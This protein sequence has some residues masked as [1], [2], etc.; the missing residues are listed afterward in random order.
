MR[1]AGI[2]SL[3]DEFIV[4]GLR[5]IRTFE[6]MDRAAL[7]EGRR[8]V[9]VTGL[10]EVEL[11][12]LFRYSS[13]T[14]LCE[15]KTLLAVPYDGDALKPFQ[16]CTDQV[17]A[18]DG[19]T[20]Y[21]VDLHRGLLSCDVAADNPELSFI[22]LPEIE[23]W[24]DILNHS[25]IL[26]ELNRTVGVCKGLVKF[27]DVDNGRFET[28]RRTN[29]FTVTT[30]VLNKIAVPAKWAKVSVL[31]VNDEL[32]TLPNFRDSP[33]PQSAPLCPMVSSKDVRLFHFILEEVQYLN[34]YRPPAA[35][36]PVW[37]YPS[38]PVI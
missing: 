13:A 24:K 20:M 37:P 3:G 7:A 18:A 22:R 14:D 23:V 17:L 31:Q 12:E 5:L 4:A 26:P 2:V 11:A 28:R 30:W 32:W 33:L 16:W 8:S 9:D 38:P 15:L 21:W 6:G 19:S 25:R 36:A 1:P 34:P 10:K 29:R 35:T 27:V